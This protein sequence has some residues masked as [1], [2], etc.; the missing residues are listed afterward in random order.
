MSA[1]FRNES[2]LSPDFLP[3]IL[4]FREGQVRQIASNLEP[5]AEGRRGQSAFVFGPPGIGKTATVRFVFRQFEDE[6]PGVKT[7]YVNCWD[8]NTSMSVMAKV[9]N[10]LGTFV[11]RRGLGK[12]EVGG[13]FAEAV[14]KAKGGVVVCLDEVDQLIDK[15]PG[16]LYN[17]IRI[18]AAVPPTLIMISNDSHV[19]SR[20]ETRVT[21]SLS[22]EEI[23]FKPYKIGEMRSILAE[24]AKLALSSFDGAAV[25]LA[26]NH[27][28]QKGGDVRVGLQC[29]QKAARAAEKEGVSKL[30][31][32]HVRSVMAGVGGARSQILEGKLADHERAIVDIVKEASPLS[33]GDLYEMYTKSVEKPSSERMFQDYVK[34]LAKSNLVRLSDKKVGGKRMVYSV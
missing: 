8:C 14:G 2:V 29:L 20:L 19:L 10:E 30:L 3:A 11:P 33:F 32:K 31:A 26:A 6:Y 9:T 1:L 16:A 24:R 21:S 7:I 27:A 13:K 23:E 18:Q 25:M 34:H 17:L 15:E 22:A 12:D 5:V 4:P 28:V